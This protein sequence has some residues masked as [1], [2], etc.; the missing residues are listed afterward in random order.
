MT[1]SHMPECPAHSWVCLHAEGWTRMPG[2][3][4]SGWRSA[5]MHARLQSDAEPM[6]DLHG[7][8]NEVTLAPSSPHLPAA[9]APQR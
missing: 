4:T 3:S 6:Q 9:F 5:A 7:T 2:L 1:A 8:S